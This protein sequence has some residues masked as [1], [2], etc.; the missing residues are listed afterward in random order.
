MRPVNHEKEKEKR[1]CKWLLLAYEE[2]QKPD[3]NP[4]RVWA[5]LGRFNLT[6]RDVDAYLIERGYNPFERGAYVRF[7]KENLQS[8]IE[9]ANDC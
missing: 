4:W 3:F 1:I 2:S 7:V 8:V 9:N 6:R 5:E